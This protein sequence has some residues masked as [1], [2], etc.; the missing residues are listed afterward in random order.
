[1]EPS[2]AALRATLASQSEMNEW[3]ASPLHQRHSAGAE[4]ANGLSLS[5][6]E[7]RAKN[8]KVTYGLSD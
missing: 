2:E 5:L 6:Y 3:D 8:E 1:M 4:G 7:M